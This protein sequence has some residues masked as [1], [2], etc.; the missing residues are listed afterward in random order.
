VLDTWVDDVGI[1]ATKIMVPTFGGIMKASYGDKNHIFAW[2]GTDPDLRVN[3]YS[4]NQESHGAWII[5][6]AIIIA[7]AARM[8]GPPHDGMYLP[9]GVKYKRAT[10]KMCSFY[11]IPVYFNGLSPPDGKIAIKLKVYKGSCRLYMIKNSMFNKFVVTDPRSTST[12]DTLQ[13]YNSKI[14]KEQMAAHV[15]KLL[16]GD[17]PYILLNLAFSGAY[18]RASLSLSG[19]AGQTSP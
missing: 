18:I 1:D 7:G 15:G 6:S 2:T 3:C 13:H 11:E 17:D 4:W 8:K 10:R 9:T 19:D 14:T 5:P 12:I 16:A